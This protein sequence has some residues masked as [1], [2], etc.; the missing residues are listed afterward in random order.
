MRRVNWTIL[1]VGLIGTA[2]MV[3]LLYSGF[4]KDPKALPD[5]LTGREAPVFTLADLQGR[6]W[7]LADIDKPVFINFW[8]TW[9]GPCKMEH[10]MLL[11]AAREYSD[12]QF[13][14]VI[15]DDKTVKVAMQMQRPPYDA[16]MDALDQNGVVY[17]NLDD[18][19]GRVALD[20]GVGGVP[21]SFFV[22]RSGQITHKEVG[23]LSPQKLRAE[24]DRIRAK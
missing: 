16:L 8:S 14:G 12:V 9:C 18:P 21:E 4:G 15:Y 10:P 13:I 1:S 7:S 5:E 23:P 19:S 3:A 17:P 2:L 22:D 11:Q 24:L 20:Y 6:E